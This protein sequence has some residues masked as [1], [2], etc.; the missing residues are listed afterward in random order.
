MA[1]ALFA[2]LPLAFRGSAIGAPFA[3][4]L[5]SAVAALTW[6]AGYV[7]SFR[8]SL[9]ALR[10]GEISPGTFALG[11]TLIAATVSLL[12]WNVVAPTEGSSRRYLLALISAL[13]IAGVNF[14]VTVLRPSRRSR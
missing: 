3:L 2:L 11:L 12:A 1:V 5:F 13:A 4:R 6:L 10:S 7:F 9:A 8:R 14:I